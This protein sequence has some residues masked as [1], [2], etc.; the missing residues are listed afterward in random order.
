MRIPAMAIVMRNMSTT[1]QNIVSIAD[2]TYSRRQR[3][4]QCAI[5]VLVALLGVPSVGSATIPWL[6]AW[7]KADPNNPADI[8]EKVLHMLAANEQAILDRSTYREF[9]LFWTELA[10]K[11]LQAILQAETALL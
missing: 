10:N 8:A 4:I 11:R 9:V 2:S 5:L 7:A 6:P 1:I 3:S